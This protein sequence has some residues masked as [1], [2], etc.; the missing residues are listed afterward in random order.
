MHAARIPREYWRHRLQMAKAMGCNTVCAYLFW[1][2]HESRP[3][4]F[5]FT[6]QADAAEYCRIAQEVGLW[7]ILR[8]GPYSCAEWEFGGFPSWLLKTPDIKLRTRD[9]RYLEPVKRY[10]LRMGRELA[11]MQI[12]RGGPILMVQVENEY[13]SY[14]NDRQYIAAIRDIIKQAGFDVPMFTCDGPEQLKNDVLD[15]LFCVVNFGSDPAANMKALHAI[16]PRGPLMCGEY[17]P[18][19]VRQLGQATPHR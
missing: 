9:P 7:V 10:L 12:T 3:G 1:N 11:P 19:L 14:G 2:Q 13:G 18:R 4:V 16:R 17:Y 6:G 8:P 15:D 5:D